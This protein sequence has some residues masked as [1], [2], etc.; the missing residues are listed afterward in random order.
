M[1]WE[2]A[3]ERRR[4]KEGLVCVLNTS[5]H[6]CP[7]SF[8]CLLSLFTPTTFL[9]TPSTVFS[10]LFIQTAFLLIALSL[11]KRVS[12]YAFNC[13]SSSAFLLIA[14]LTPS[15]VF[16]PLSSLRLSNH[17]CPCSL[18]CCLFFT[19]GVDGSSLSF[20]CGS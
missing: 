11:S 13:L 2:E 9:L 12:P 4:R 16:F 6:V 17:V 3:L 20:L 15:T 10:P 19:S 5:N 8:N 14:L 18:Q 7:Y 1:G